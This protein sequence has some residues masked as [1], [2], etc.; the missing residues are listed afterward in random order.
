MRRPPC[1]SAQSA[2]M[3]KAR[4]P[5]FFGFVRDLFDLGKVRE[6]V[7]DDICAGLSEGPGSGPP[8]I[9]PRCR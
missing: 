7:D 4:D 6:A 5:E 1:E 8:D 9:L 2:K 3:G